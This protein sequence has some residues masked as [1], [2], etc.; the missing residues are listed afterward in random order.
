MKDIKLLVVWEREKKAGSVQ[1]GWYNG[2]QDRYRKDQQ[3]TAR[4][5]VSYPGPTCAMC[6][7]CARKL[8]VK[9]YLGDVVVFTERFKVRIEFMNAILMSLDSHFCNTVSK[10]RPEIISDKQ[11]MTAFDGLH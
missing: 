3:E 4:P 8:C 1:N 5:H 10:L 6:Q 9:T 7:L 2:M 11:Q